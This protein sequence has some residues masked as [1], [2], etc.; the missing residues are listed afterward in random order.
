MIWRA[1]EKN[2][3]GGDLWGRWAYVVRVGFLEIS[4]VF[5]IIILFCFGS[6]QFYL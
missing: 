5:I 1:L 6:L 3:C 4:F 2:L